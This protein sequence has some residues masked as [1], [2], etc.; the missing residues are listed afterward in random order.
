MIFACFQIFVI[1]YSQTILVKRS[2]SQASTSGPAGC[3]RNLGKRDRTLG[4][5]SQFHSSESADHYAWRERLW[6]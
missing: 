1:L 5:G 3:F 4:G 6:A 2:A